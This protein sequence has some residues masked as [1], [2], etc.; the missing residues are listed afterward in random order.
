M[1]I[2]FQETSVFRIY[3]KFVVGPKGLDAVTTNLLALG[4]VGQNPSFY[5]PPQYCQRKGATSVHISGMQTRW[6]ELL[7]WLG[8]FLTLSHF[9]S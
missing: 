1:R 3:R 6:E 9:S 2:L 5:G 4:R 8:F 7:D